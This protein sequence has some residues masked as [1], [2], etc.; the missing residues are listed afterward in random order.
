MKPIASLTKFAIYLAGYAVACVWSETWADGPGA[1]IWPPDA[2]LLLALLF[3]RPGRWWWYVLGALPIR[4][5]VL[6]PAPQFVLWSLYANDSLKAVLSASLLRRVLPDAPRLNT[7]RDFAAFTLIAAVFS[8]LL[9]AFTGAAVRVRLGDAFWGVWVRWFL[10]DSLAIIALVPAF[11]FAAQGRFRR[12]LVSAGELTALAASLIF[13]S[14]LAF[15]YA[16]RAATYTPL[17]LYAPIPALVWAAVRVGPAGVSISLAFMVLFALAGA[18]VGHGPFAAYGQAVNQLAVQLF[19]NLLA[20]PLTALTLL[21]AE[22]RAAQE[23]LAWS[24]RQLQDQNIQLRT[25]AGRLMSA[26]EDERQRISRDLHDDIGQRL[27]LIATAIDRVNLA[28]HEPPAIVG[29]GLQGIRT[30]VHELASDLHGLS[31]ELYSSTVQHL[32][33]AGALRNW[34]T[35]MTAQHH[36]AIEF[37]EDGHDGLPRG[38]SMCLYQVAQESVKNAIAHSSAERVTIELTS[39]SSSMRLRVK[40]SGVGFDPGAPTRGIG[41][42]SLRERLRFIGGALSVTSTPGSGAEVLAEIPMTSLS[43][44]ASPGR[45]DVLRRSLGT[46]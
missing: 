40:D 26:H 15:W 22:R 17:F 39:D 10:G 30:E 8:P 38:A 12:P 21:I 11:L 6:G 2:V 14:W 45:A 16:D 28:H 36:L 29:S 31:R 23:A 9:S 32:G 35:Q 42:A 25:L 34:C 4:W 3:E 46:A 19:L 37:I 33:L 5:F 44:D 13:G 1:A 41:L 27:A 7:L 20:V 24:E 43:P 18:E